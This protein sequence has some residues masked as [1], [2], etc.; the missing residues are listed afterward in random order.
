MLAS[1]GGRVNECT[2][3]CKEYSEVWSW[4]TESCTGTLPNTA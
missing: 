4:W 2:Y 1:E 3:I